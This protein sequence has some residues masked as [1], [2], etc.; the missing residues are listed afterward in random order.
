VRIERL[1]AS[2]TGEN[3]AVWYQ[4]SDET[5]RHIAVVHRSGIVFDQPR[6]GLSS[7]GIWNQAGSR[8]LFENGEPGDSEGWDRLGVL[9]VDSR[10]ITTKKLRSVTEEIDV[11]LPQSHIV[12]FNADHSR[13]E[14]ILRFADEYDE[15]GN[16]LQSRKQPGAR[17]SA[18]C[19]YS[20]EFR[21]AHGPIATHVYDGV[22]G[23]TIFAFP[24]T[25]DDSVWSELTQWSPCDDR[26]AIVN[27]SGKYKVFDVEKK[28]YVLEL[29][30]DEQGA[31]FQFSNDGSEIIRI[32]RGKITRI[33]LPRRW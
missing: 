31:V 27:L 26:L 16:F 20:T 30:D 29:G 24:T 8:L 7:Q 19:K 13:G 15:N 1:L 3:I 11:C 33:E 28:F 5:Q 21:S 18:T 17:Y 14:E 25:T 2:P 4:S 9:A 23:E 22:T 10:T 32:E 6:I 12:V